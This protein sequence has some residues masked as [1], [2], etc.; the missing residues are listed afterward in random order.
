MRIHNNNFQKNAN[1]SLV[2]QTIWKNNGISRIDIAR[3]LNLYRSTVSN[4]I[5][6]L[7]DAGIV[8]EAESGESAAQGGRRPILLKVR[9]DSGC[10]LGLELQPNRFRAIIVDIYGN[11]L[12]YT[13]DALEQQDFPDFFAAAVASVSDYLKSCPMPLLGICAGIPGIVDTR[14]QK[15]IY[16]DPFKLLDFPFAEKIASQYTVPVLIENDANC[17]TWEDL[18]R[19]RDQTQQDFLS[20][21]TAYHPYDGHSEKRFGIGVGIGIAREGKLFYGKHYS[22]GEF[23]SCEWEPEC[24]GQFDLEENEMRRLK[25][26]EQVYRHLV[27]E[28]F[29]TIKTIVMVLDPAA[30]FFHGDICEN[31]ELA[32][33]VLR[34]EG[35]ALQSV[36]DKTGCRME[37]SRGGSSDVAHGAASMFLGRLFSVP[38]LTDSPHYTHLNW[39][40]VFNMVKN[41]TREAAR[42]P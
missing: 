35:R 42:V 16:S 13:E 11:T 15:I 9:E 8:Y 33:D 7:L 30:L 3:N 39:E 4:I 18:A 40:D 34:N 22:A 29:K 24:I 28:L 26:D 21:L 41:G 20:V 6:T 1:I 23:V 17:C 27:R 32:M 10:V 37:F 12:H 31:R 5:Q 2:A 36:L 25:Q 38:E 14:N 19:Y